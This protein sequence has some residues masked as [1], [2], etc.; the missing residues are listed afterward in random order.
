VKSTV[1]SATLTSLAAGSRSAGCPG[2]LAGTPEA[3]PEACPLEQKPGHQVRHLRRN[4]SKNIGLSWQQASCRT[5][6]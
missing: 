3:K 1:I 4:T 6:L 5:F 2:R